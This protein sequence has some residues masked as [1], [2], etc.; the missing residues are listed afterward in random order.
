MHSAPDM[1]DFRHAPLLR[2]PFAE[3]FD[4]HIALIRSARV[5]IE[6]EPEQR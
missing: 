2:H 1:A 4:R 6:T 3:Q 5:Q